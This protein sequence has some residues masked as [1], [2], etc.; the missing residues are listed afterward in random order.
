[1]TPDQIKTFASDLRR[2]LYL[3]KILD[4]NIEAIR[5]LPIPTFIR[6]NLNNMFNN[7]NR[8]RDD[9]NHKMNGT[10]AKVVMD[11]LAKDQMHD[12]SCIL[13]ILAD[14]VNTGEV[15]AELQAG[16]RVY[17]DPI[18]NHHETVEGC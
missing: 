4:Y 3:L 11:D 1:M 12:L 16:K 14:V 15:L 8:F 17:K 10:S 6:V 18:V 9:L 2:I 7:H 5:E 13:D